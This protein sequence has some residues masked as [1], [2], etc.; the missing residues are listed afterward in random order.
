MDDDERGPEHSEPQ[1]GHP[2][3]RPG[4]PNREPEEPQPGHPQGDAPT[5]YDELSP[6]DVEVL[7]AF[8]ALEELKVGDAASS[9]LRSES[10]AV[11]SDNDTAL[12]T[13][14]EMLL[15]F[16]SEVD[17][18][19]SILQQTLQ[20]LE[21]DD[22]L[23][24]GRLLTLQRTAHKLKGTTGSMECGVLSSIAY[25][26]EAV[27]KLL[28]R[29]ALASFVGL[30]A[31]IQA[32]QAFERTFHDFVT[33]GKESDT[34]LT[35]LES[36]YKALAIAIPPPRKTSSTPTLPE[37]EAMGAEGPVRVLL[38]PSSDDDTLFPHA[39]SRTEQEALASLHV[40]I[41]RFEQLVTRT[42]QLVDLR[43]PLENAQ[44]QV[45]TSLQDLQ[46]AQARLWRL[47]TLFSSLALSSK[48]SHTAES[49][50][51]SEERSNSSLI[52]RILDEAQQRTGHSYQRKSIP[53]P[54]PMQVVANRI[55]D[56][57]E[58]DRYTDTEVL[59]QSLSEAIADVAT[60]STRLRSAFTQLHRIT[61][62]YTQ[63]ASNVRDDT[64]LLR[65]APLS[66]LLSRIERT[67]KMSAL[68][69]QEQVEFEVVGETIGI[70]QDMLEA[71][72]QPLLQLI[73]TCTATSSPLTGKEGE[74]EQKQEKI[75][76]RIWFHAS[77]SSSEVRIEVG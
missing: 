22:S 73:R 54:S 3:S 58:I 28:A 2:E 47:E 16:V 67:V 60:A 14:E 76:H 71:L 15:L 77:A 34:A 69:Q 25:Y 27:A 70:E 9:A 68:A 4:Q 56:E 45:D 46:L 62:Q 23:D 5:S 44:K 37:K 74:V 6:E 59:I 20:R 13:P 18:D 64:L 53:T 30:N 29:N 19:L 50:G 32:V 10:K 12:P 31:L 11:L 57:M 65:L 63:Q 48:F 41:H 38:K 72:K 8:D 43:A 36:E 21:P 33:D 66:I 55:W 52:A 24:P 39:V 7:R 35:E 26:I 75:P 1:Q 40:D 61:Q 42:D 51:Y 49:R 17:E